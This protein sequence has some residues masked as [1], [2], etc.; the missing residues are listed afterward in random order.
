MAAVTASPLADILTAALWSNALGVAVRP[1]EV[2]PLLGLARQARRLR[3][4]PAPPHRRAPVG[5]HACELLGRV[6]LLAL[7]EGGEA[8][9]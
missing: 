7:Q 9:R 6:R 5:A 4:D 3:R 1:E 8:A 2:Q